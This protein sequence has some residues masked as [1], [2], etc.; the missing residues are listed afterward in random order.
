MLLN[1]SL[2]GVLAK[3]KHVQEPRHFSTAI[4][5]LPHALRPH[6]TWIIKVIFLDGCLKTL[7]TPCPA[8]SQDRSR[9]HR[10]IELSS[11][12]A[13]KQ[14]CLASSTYTLSMPWCEEQHIGLDWFDM[15]WSVRVTKRLLPT[16]PGTAGLNPCVS[17][18]A[19]QRGFVPL[20]NRKNL[21]L[22]TEL[23]GEGLAVTQTCGA[24]LVTVH[25]DPRAP[26]LSGR[27]RN[28]LTSNSKQRNLC[29]MR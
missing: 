24:V 19:W 6:I 28:L 25:L 29:E 4:F 8:W 11:L 23:L 5:H 20:A 22:Q 7:A 9:R 13:T 27:R 16:P 17:L 14:R 3:L 26:E 10:F 12:H 21:R 2:W 18:P 15:V 1:L